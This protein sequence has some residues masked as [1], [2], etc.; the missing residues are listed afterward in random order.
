MNDLDTILPGEG[1]EAI[2]DFHSRDHAEEV[3]S[4]ITGRP[5]SHLPRPKQAAESPATPEALPDSR[6]S[7][8]IP[9]CQ[10]PPDPDAINGDR[11]AWAQQALSAFTD[12]TGTDAEDALCDLLADLMH[13]CD[14]HGTSF[15]S[16]LE[17][18]RCHYAAETGEQ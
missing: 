8:A 9:G 12:A 6:E 13:W 14:R 7:T 11:A 17:R 18:A 2:G 10:C 5:Y 15:S 16:E 4:R 1:V 3:F